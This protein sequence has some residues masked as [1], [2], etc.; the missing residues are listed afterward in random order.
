MSSVYRNIGIAL[1]LSVL[2][3]SVLLLDEILA[4]FVVGLILGYLGDPLVDR[5]EKIRVPRTSGVLAVFFVFGSFFASALFILLPLIL[6]EFSSLM[7]SLPRIFLWFQ[8]SFG[9]TLIETFGFDPFG[10]K[11]EQIRGKVL[12]NWAEAGGIIGLIISRITDSAF[13]FFSATGNF[14]LSLIVAF[15][16]M[17]DFDSIVEKTHKLIPHRHQAIVARLGR[18]CDEILGAFLR[19]QMWVMFSMGCLFSFGLYMLGI[20]QALSIGFLAGLASIIPYLGFV[21]G[22]L[23]AS[24]AALIQFGDF[25]F[26]INVAL[27]FLVAQFIESVL[28]TPWFVGDRIGLHPLAV[29]FSLMVGGY[30]FGFIGVLLALPLSAVAMVLLRHFLQI[31]LSSSTYLKKREG[32]F[33]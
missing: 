16:L 20:D 26:L 29:I 24:V 21:L 8:E 4:P 9:P 12:E 2:V 18:E 33:E 10:I 13:S 14:F 23:G 22:F 32:T 5:L 25:L 28:L 1:A 27:V 30:L 11:P 3:A 19:G 31:Y 17:I 7:K 15:Y 6:A